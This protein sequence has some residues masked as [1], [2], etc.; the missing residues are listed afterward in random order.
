LV[1]DRLTY[2]L[3]VTNTF[4]LSSTHQVVLTDTLP[5]GT[6]FITA[7]MP[8]TADGDTITW[9]W[10]TIAAGGRRDVELVVEVAPFVAWSPI[11]NDNYGVRSEETALETG[12]AVETAVLYLRD[13]LP[14]IRE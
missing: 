9:Q 13:F 7:T 6:T 10:A 1:G 12:D 4:T 5:A 14:F 2:T 8:Y 11:V 3:S